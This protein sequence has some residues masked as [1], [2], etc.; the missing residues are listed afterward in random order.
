MCFHRKRMKTVMAKYKVKTRDCQL[1]VGVRLSLKEKINVTQLDFFSNRYIRGLLK[2]KMI[3]K[4]HIEYYGPI[5]ILNKNHRAIA[6]TANT[7][8]AI[9]KITET[10]FSISA[11]VTSSLLH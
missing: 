9:K 11:I 3:K 6:N 10:V 1:I 8:A 2:V 7:P 5:G 4:S